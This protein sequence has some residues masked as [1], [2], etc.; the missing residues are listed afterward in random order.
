M[1]ILLSPLRRAGDGSCG[2]RAMQVAAGSK[3]RGR[4]QDWRPRR[5]PGI[6]PL[7]APAPAR[8]VAHRTACAC[9]GSCP[10]CRGKSPVEANLTIGEPGDAFE[11][12]A[13]RLAARV[14]NM[15]GAAAPTQN[16]AE[17][18]AQR[19]GEEGTPVAKAPTASLGAGQPLPAGE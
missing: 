10:R 4:R 15:P 6:D 8:Q 16:A 12:E 3:E 7:R 2:M 14:L 1:A 9:G 13:D 5:P 17:R 11:L 18:L 19:A